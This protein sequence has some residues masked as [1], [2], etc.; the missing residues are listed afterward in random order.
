MVAEIRTPLHQGSACFPSLI[1]G[2]D[3][4]DV[5][6]YDTVSFWCPRNECDNSHMYLW[7]PHSFSRISCKGFKIFSARSLSSPSSHGTPWFILSSLL[8]SCRYIS[9]RAIPTI[10]PV[11]MSTHFQ[12]YWNLLW[13]RYAIVPAVWFFRNSGLMPEGNRI[14]TINA[15]I[16]SFVNEAK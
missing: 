13:C 3:P 7:L 12:V 4:N 6:I 9:P 1:L 14:L 10:S 11:S 16:T 2:I 8:R 15:P 5:Y